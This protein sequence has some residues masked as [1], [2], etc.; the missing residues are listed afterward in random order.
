[1]LRAHVFRVF[2]S[3][4]QSRSF[5]A[6]APTAKAGITNINNHGAPNA[7]SPERSTPTTDTPSRAKANNTANVTLCPRID[8]QNHD[9]AETGFTRFVKSHDF[10]VVKG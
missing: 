7:P 1:M 4:I 10:L 5:L 3:G 9:V 8:F 6:K 2:S